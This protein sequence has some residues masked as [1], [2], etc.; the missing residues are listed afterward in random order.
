[1]VDGQNIITAVK[2]VDDIL[3]IGKKDSI[4]AY[5]ITLENRK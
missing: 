2:Y 1:M 4:D 5:K 3:I